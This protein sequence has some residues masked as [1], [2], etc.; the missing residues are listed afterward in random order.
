MQSTKLGFCLKVQLLLGITLM[1]SIFSPIVAAVV[2]PEVELLKSFGK[3]E[4]NPRG[5]LVQDADGNLYGTTQFGGSNGLGSLYKIDKSGKYSVLDSFDGTNNKYPSIVGSDGKLYGF[6]STGGSANKGV[7]F[8]LDPSV[9]TSAYNVIQELD[10]PLIASNQGN[11]GKIYG[12]TWSGSTNKGTN[13]QL[14]TSGAKPA[15][16]VLNEF[17]GFID[18]TPTFDSSIFSILGRDGKLYNFVSRTTRE[19][20]GPITRNAMLYQIDISGSTPAANLLYTIKLLNRDQY[21]SSAIQG[22]DGKFYGIFGPGNSDDPRDKLFQLDISQTMPVYTVLHEFPDFALVGEVFQGRDG[23]LYGTTTKGSDYGADPNTADCNVR[24]FQIDLYSTTPNY[25]VLHDFTCNNDPDRPLKVNIIQSS[26]GKLYG[27]TIND[28]SNG[29]GTVFELDL[30]GATPSYNLVHEFAG[31]EDVL[32]VV[33]GS[34]GNFYGATYNQLGS[35]FRLDIARSMSVVSLQPIFDLFSKRKLTSLFKGSGGKYFGSTAKGGKFDLGTVFQLD[36]SGATPSYSVLHEFDNSGVSNP[37]SI[38]QGND[39][40]LY[41]VT[42]DNPAELFR[43]DISGATPTY[44]VMKK[45]ESYQGVWPPPPGGNVGI[46]LGLINSSYGKLYGFTANG[47]MVGFGA[48]FRFDFTGVTTVHEF[49]P[50]EIDGAVPSSLIQ[51]SDGKLYGTTSYGGVGLS[52]TAYKID[53]SGTIPAYSILHSFDNASYSPN[54]L[55]QGVDGKLYGMARSANDSAAMFLL[56]I[57]EAAPIYM[58]LYKFDRINLT[59]YKYERPNSLLQG[60]D[61]NFYVYKDGGGQYGRGAIYLLRMPKL[62]TPPV[63]ANDSFSLAVPKKNTP[64]TIAAPGILG[65]DKDAEGKVLAVFGATAAAKPKIIEFPQGGGKVALYADG[66]FVY[67]PGKKCFYG[68]R[69]F[70]YQATDGQDASNPA[71]VTL[72]TKRPKQEHGKHEGRKHKD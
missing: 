10:A 55:I 31:S 29:T 43:L 27:T 53:T 15:Y 25:N 42:G 30:S 17:T 40:H 35:M 71:T 56:D 12:V 4:G 39:G 72:T 66:H 60:S 16:T 19:N 26:D 47:G 44:T 64:I 24:V 13:F 9:S 28:G 32:P 20:S 22:S 48:V 14:D 41:G 45:F 46:P 61:G 3:Q 38:V 21:I 7:I 68:T 54:N 69:S 23:K 67:T 50:T 36:T 33:R 57:S 34:D 70:T 63:A 18:I 11:D 49:G 51:G 8:Q 65:N 2:L 37:I 52:G 1:L 59:P 5:K 58:V 6:T 62:N